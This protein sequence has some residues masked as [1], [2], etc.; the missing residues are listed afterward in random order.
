MGHYKLANATQTQ[1]SK[2]SQYYATILALTDVFAC[3]NAS[4]LVER[5]LQLMVRKRKLECGFS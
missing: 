2:Q 5:L 4:C 1:K 3:K